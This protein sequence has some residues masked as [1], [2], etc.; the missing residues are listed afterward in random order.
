M[1]TS[2]HPRENK[3]APD[4]MNGSVRQM[5][6]PSG[7]RSSTLRRPNHTK[8]IARDRRKSAYPIRS[9]QSVLSMM[10]SRN[11]EQ[12]AAAFDQHGEEERGGRGKP[13][14]SSPPLWGSGLS[15]YCE[16]AFDPRDVSLPVLHGD[17]Q[18]AL[19][20]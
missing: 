2:Q 15:S 7:H 18:R 16:R 4:G 20:Q 10:T 1:I 3:N 6:S 5:K 11:V 19:G 9:I 12:D 17:C 14:L 8:M 13:W